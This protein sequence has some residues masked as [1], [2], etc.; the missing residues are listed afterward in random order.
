MED[1][2]SDIRNRVS[3][4]DA[5]RFYGLH[6]N[7]SGMACCPFHDDKTPSLKVYSDHFYCFGCGAT[8]DCTGFVAKLFG[9]SQYEAAKR[10][11]HDFGLHLFDK[12][13]TVPVNER[14]RSEN[15]YHT[16]L[17]K[18]NLTVSEYLKKLNEWRKIYA[19]QN[20]DEQINPL[21][22]ESLQRMGYVEYLADV[23]AYGMEQE[24]RELYEKNSIEI[25]KIRKR[26]DKFTA[27]GHI[28]K[29]KVI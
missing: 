3:M 9:I 18:A 7:R 12:E 27:E 20:M 24:K 11:S 2:F 25:Q 21:F 22:A 14:L 13:I 23:L 17:R 29:R 15:D 4:Q 19:P 16:W 26:L 5:A 28:V 1:I 8:D 10:I 6:I